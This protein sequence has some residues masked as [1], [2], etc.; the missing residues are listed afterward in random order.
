VSSSASSP[1]SHK[2]GNGKNK[3]LVEDIITITEKI[4]LTKSQHQALKIV[5]EIFQQSFSEY[6]QHAVVQTMKSEIED[7]NLSIALLERLD[8]GPGEEET[9]KSVKDDKKGT[10]EG[11][12]SMSVLDELARLNKLSGPRLSK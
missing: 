6:I 5:C 9:V 8:D 1:L 7:D 10:G 4:N 11:F 12:D 2:I 3:N